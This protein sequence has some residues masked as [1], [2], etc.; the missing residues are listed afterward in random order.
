[1]CR[2]RRPFWLPRRGRSGPGPPPPAPPVLPGP[3]VRLRT[4][5]RAPLWCSGA[6]GG[7][8]SRCRSGTCFRETEGAL[9]RRGARGRGPRGRGARSPLAAGPAPLP[10]AGPGPRDHAGGIPHCSGLGRALGVAAT[11]APNHQRRAA[12]ALP[13]GPPIHCS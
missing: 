9:A 10:A 1:M 2:A 13:A 11:P 8:W 4:G 6:A 7:P 5:A 12:P 3:R